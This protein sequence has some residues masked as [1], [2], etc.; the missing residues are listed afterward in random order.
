M[1]AFI[2]RCSTGYAGKQ[3]LRPPRTEIDIEGSVEDAR[4]QTSC[5]CGVQFD[6]RK[7]WMWN[8]LRPLGDAIAGTR[9]TLAAL[10]DIGKMKRVRVRRT[11]PAPA[12]RRYSLYIGLAEAD[13]RDFTVQGTLI[14]RGM[15]LIGGNFG[16]HA[17]LV[18]I[19]F[20][21]AFLGKRV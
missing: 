8:S 21:E 18:E 4:T 5:H 9:G 15:R 12:R 20:D 13:D 2:L 19:G 6:L 17:D 7:R 10:V 3:G 11:Q 14:G 16:Q 1:P